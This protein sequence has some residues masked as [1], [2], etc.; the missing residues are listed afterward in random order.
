MSPGIVFDL[1]EWSGQEILINDIR[2]VD[3]NPFPCGLH[4]LLTGLSFR[5]QDLNV[6]LTEFRPRY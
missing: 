4:G 5:Y 1:D 6:R 3:G 2:T